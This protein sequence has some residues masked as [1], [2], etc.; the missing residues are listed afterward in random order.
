MN[1]RLQS[2]KKIQSRAVAFI[3]VIV[4]LVVILVLNFVS[5]HLF[6]GL[7][8]K[9]FAPMWNTRNTAV[10]YF[11]DSF[12]LLR[13][14][15]DLTQEIMTLRGKIEEN[16]FNQS[17]IALI[18]KENVELKS[19]LG[20]EE[21]GNKKIL[22]AVLSQPELLPYDTFIIDVG[23]REGI[24]ADS[25][26]YSSSGMPIAKVVEVH[27]STSKAK[28]YSS[29]DET[30]QVTIGRDSV[31]TTAFGKGGGTFEVKLPRG[32]EIKVGDFVVLPGIAPLLF[33]TVEKIEMGE[34]DSFQLVYFK[35]P[36]NISQ[37]RFVFVD[38]QP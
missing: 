4:V 32:T 25:T 7:F 30:L 9:I 14:K 6:S 34:S 21:T 33:S 31:Q 15:N 19:L 11:N 8:A 29:H 37:A 5:P 1:Y 38:T 24:R 20:R 26:V 27:N 22:A 10:Y 3:V 12:K 23:I 13:S 18:Q 36:Y 35:N 28:L 2:R 16:E 17:Q